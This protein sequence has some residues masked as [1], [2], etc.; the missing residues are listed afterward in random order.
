MVNYSGENMT[1]DNVSAPFAN[2]RDDAQNG[3]G[4]KQGNIFNTF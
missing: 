3:D 1:D 2:D 4:Q